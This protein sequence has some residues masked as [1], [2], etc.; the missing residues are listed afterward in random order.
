[1]M[2]K[3]VTIFSAILIVALAAGCNA[4]GTADKNNSGAENQAAS[5]QGTG[6]IA[7]GV[8]APDITLTAADG[9]TVSLA[10]LHKDKPVYVNFWATWC[11]PCVKEMP[12]INA[13]HAKYGDKI[14]FVAVSVDEQFSDAQSFMANRQFTVPLYTGDLK[15]IFTAYHIEGI[16]VS[17]LIGKDGKILFYHIGMMDEQQMETLMKKAV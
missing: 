12:D 15:Q 3:M 6:E 14:N 17:L 10:S 11:P 9:S 1:M 2:K 7:V 13:M 16:P 4:D 8:A 5:A